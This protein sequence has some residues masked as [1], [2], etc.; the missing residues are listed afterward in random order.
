MYNLIHMKDQNEFMELPEGESR[1]AYSG[2]AQEDHHALADLIRSVGKFGTWM[3]TLIP[4]GTK[5]VNGQ[6]PLKDEA[7]NH[8]PPTSGIRR[9]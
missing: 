2:Q 4:F 1:G 5:D 6:K 7:R 9:N 3:M 8:P